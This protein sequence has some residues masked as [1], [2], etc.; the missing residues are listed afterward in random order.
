M[1]PSLHQKILKL[2]EGAH[3][4]KAKPAQ[5]VKVAPVLLCAIRAASDQ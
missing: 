2:R 3:P 4:D 5:P 1:L